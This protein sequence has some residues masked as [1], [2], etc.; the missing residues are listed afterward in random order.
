MGDIGTPRRPT[1]GAVFRGLFISKGARKG[2]EAR[3]QAAPAWPWGDLLGK[4]CGNFGAVPPTQAL[5][6]DVMRVS[7]GN[8]IASSV[9]TV[10]CVSFSIVFV[11]G[12]SLERDAL[13]E[14]YDAT[15]GAS[16]KA[17]LQLLL[18]GTTL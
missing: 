15:N 5:V 8:D 2:T 18:A 17:Q 11:H 7:M 12:A 1:T 3:P 4:S 9:V 14:L 6:S 13:I 10:L 16:W